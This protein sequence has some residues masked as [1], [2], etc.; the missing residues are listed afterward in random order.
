MLENVDQ[1]K[2]IND[3]GMPHH[4]RPFMKGRLFIHF[5]VDFPESGVFSL[6]QC[7][8]LETILPTRPSKHLTDMERDDCEETT[9]HDVNI[10]EEMRRK[11]QQQHRHH[12]AYDED[13]DEP[14]MPRV[15]CAQQ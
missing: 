12:E 11:E 5:N 10:E 2:A 13:D 1:Y 7:R 14:S 9:L 8:T 4:Q 3:E 6:E 15:Q